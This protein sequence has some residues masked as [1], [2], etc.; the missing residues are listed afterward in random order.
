MQYSANYSLSSRPSTP[1]SLHSRTIPY[2]MLQASDGSASPPDTTWADSTSDLGRPYSRER[3]SS[4][5]RFGGKVSSSGD[6][7]SQINP[8]IPRGVCTDAFIGAPEQ[9]FSEF[10][11]LQSRDLGSLLKNQPGKGTERAKLFTLAK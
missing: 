10:I 7:K 6:E 11:C 5:E 2:G 9:H 4:I 8:V 1:H 3:L